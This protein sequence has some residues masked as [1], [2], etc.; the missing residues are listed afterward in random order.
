MLNMSKKKN[1]N[2][3]VLKSLRDLGQNGRDTLSRLATTVKADVPTVLMNADTIKSDGLPGF[4]LKQPIKTRVSKI[5]RKLN[6]FIRNPEAAAARR[7]KDIARQMS[8]AHTS[9]PKVRKSRLP[10][11]VVMCAAIIGGGGYYAYESI[12][13]SDVK[14]SN[15]V[16]YEG[17]LSTA[18]GK[19]P[20]QTTVK[21][22]SSV[23]RSYSVQGNRHISK[24]LTKV[25]EKTFRKLPKQ[26][27]KQIWQ[28]RL[29]K[30]KAKSA[31]K[32][33]TSAYKKKSSGKSNSSRAKLNK[34]SGKRKQFTAAKTSRSSQKRR[35]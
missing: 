16:D 32:Y 23:T 29:A 31:A 9:T 10:L 17:W 15:Y 1:K 5:A 3:H 11:V 4:K 13:F 20:K 12:N 26:T 14:L 25:P 33:K 7:L 27:K 35:R 21:P 30:A 34:S 22:S 28:S 2:K 6:P 8:A 18:S 19:Q 24:T